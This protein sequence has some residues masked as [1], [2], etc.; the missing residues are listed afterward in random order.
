MIS[1]IV[2][3]AAAD[4]VLYGL[5]L[6]SY[7]CRDAPERCPVLSLHNIYKFHFKSTSLVPLP[8]CRISS[9]IC[10]Q[11]LED[12]ST[13]VYNL[14]KDLAQKVIGANCMNLAPPRMRS[15]S[16]SRLKST[17]SMMSLGSTGS[18]PVVITEL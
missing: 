17:Y 18:R 4:S 3:C 14:N 15:T 10:S 13:A 8:I 1:F 16:S 12:L 2:T 11:S 6:L 9:D 5:L 7:N